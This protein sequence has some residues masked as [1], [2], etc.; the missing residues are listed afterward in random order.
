MLQSRDA[1]LIVG[2]RVL[3]ARW[4]QD[5]CEAPYPRFERIREVLLG[6][7]EVCGNLLGPVVVDTA[8]MNYLNL[9]GQS[10]GSYRIGELIRGFEPPHEAVPPGSLKEVCMVWQ[11]QNHGV[12]LRVESKYVLQS[13]RSPSLIIDTGAGVHADGRPLPERVDAMHT[14][15]NELFPTILTDEAKRLFAYD[16]SL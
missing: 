5:Y 12:E 11:E 8:N 7:V 14:A 2:P 6:A 15:L 13:D 16:S 4:N 3:S 1:I 9:V 10:S